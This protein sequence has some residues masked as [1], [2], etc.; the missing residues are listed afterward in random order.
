MKNLLDDGGILKLQVRRTTR[1]SEVKDC[2]QP[3]DRV[4]E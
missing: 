2:Q 4:S 1:Y 3:V